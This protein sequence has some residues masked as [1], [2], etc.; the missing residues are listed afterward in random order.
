MKKALILHAWFQQIDDYWYP[1]LAT[2]LKKKRY[3]VLLPDLPI[4]RTD[5]PDMETLLKNIIDLHFL[6]KDTTVIGHSLG[7]VLAMRL[8]EKYPY[9]KMILV[10]GWDYND[11]TQGHRLFWETM[12]DHS[13]IRN[14]VKEI[15]VLSSDNDPYTTAL[16][17]EEMSK[18]LDG[19]FILIK[20]A[21]H[22]CKEIE[23]N[24]I[25]KILEIA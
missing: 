22:F 1:W 23:D 6:D 9:K 14:N 7:A 13:K 11:L 15:Y 8:A 17:A 4:M 25:P 19:T 2:E 18:R 24:K 16:N 21:G 3:D 5:M 20:G 12:I 10:A